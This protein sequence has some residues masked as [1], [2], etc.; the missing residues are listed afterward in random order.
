MREDWF[1]EYPLR[2]KLIFDSQHGPK[3]LTVG[4]WKEQPL[5]GDLPFPEN[6]VMF[7]ERIGRFKRKTGFP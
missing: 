7:H 4:Q 6:Y 1:S 2:S 5:E 3:Y